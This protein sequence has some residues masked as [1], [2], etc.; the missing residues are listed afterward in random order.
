MSEASTGVERRWS[1][2]RRELA[3]SRLICIGDNVAPDGKRA[4]RSAS[5]RRPERRGG[6]RPRPITASARGSR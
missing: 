1:P 6:V 3:T 5:P 2:S 4:R